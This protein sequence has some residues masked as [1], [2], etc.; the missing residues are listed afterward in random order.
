[1]P[2]LQKLLAGLMLFSPAAHALA[3]P[4]QA[5]EGKIRGF[6]GSADVTELTYVLSIPHGSIIWHGYEVLTPNS[7]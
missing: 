6:T 3:T 2:C 1:M 5:L 7:S 4:E